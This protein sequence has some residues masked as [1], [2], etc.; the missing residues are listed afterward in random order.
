MHTFKYGLPPTG[1]TVPASDSE[2]EIRGDNT[3]DGIFRERE[4]YVISSIVKEHGNTEEVID[5]LAEKTNS[6]QGAGRRQLYISRTHHQPMHAYVQGSDAGNTQIVSLILTAMSPLQLE[7]R[8]L[9]GRYKPLLPQKC[10][11][12]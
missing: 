7:L 10:R 2:E 9:S 3:L 12:H 4:Q 1:E 5:I 11:P 6:T 8:I